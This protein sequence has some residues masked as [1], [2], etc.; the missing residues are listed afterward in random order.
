M[1]EKRR[2]G[3]GNRRRNEEMKLRMDDEC[4]GGEKYCRTIYIGGRA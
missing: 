4:N 2:I 1:K 3:E